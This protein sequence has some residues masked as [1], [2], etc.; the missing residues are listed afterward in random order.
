MGKISWDE[1]KIKCVLVDM[2]DAGPTPGAFVVSGVTYSGTTVTVTTSAA[3]G[4]TA[5]DRFDIFSVGGV[6]NV[7]GECVVVTAGTPTSGSRARLINLEWLSNVE[8]YR[9]AQTPIEGS[10]MI[11]R[12]RPTSAT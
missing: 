2:N 1:N 7:S 3:H 8:S 10:A 12:S 11:R 4:M 6:T 9:S 5:G